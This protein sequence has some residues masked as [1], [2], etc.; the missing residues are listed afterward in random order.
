MRQVL[1]DDIRLMTWKYIEINIIRNRFGEN[2]DV[3]I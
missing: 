2:D 1:N 3:F